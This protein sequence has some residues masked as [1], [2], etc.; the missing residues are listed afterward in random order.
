MPDGHVKD[1][2]VL[3]LFEEQLWVIQVTGRCGIF[4]EAVLKNKETREKA[5]S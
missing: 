5:N 2:V 1:D 4:C 3:E